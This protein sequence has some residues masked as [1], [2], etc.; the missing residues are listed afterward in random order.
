MDSLQNTTLHRE[1]MVLA[2]NASEPAK[3]AYIQSSAEAEQ[4]SPLAIGIENSSIIKTPDSKAEQEAKEK[5]QAQIKKLHEPKSIIS[6]G[7][8]ALLSSALTY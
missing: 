2:A 6:I 5:K 3:N 7:L 4:A 8:D 1:A